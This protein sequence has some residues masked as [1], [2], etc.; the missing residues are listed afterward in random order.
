MATLQVL[1][2]R[3]DSIQK[4]AAIT[5]AMYQIS[6]SKL[7][8][9]QNAYQQYYKFKDAFD[10]VLNDV[11]NVEE[12]S[13]F[14]DKKQKSEKKLFILISGD[15]GLVGGYHVQ[16]FKHFLE[17]IK[18][19]DR[20]N[21]FLITIGRRA[22]GFA[23]KQNLQT[24]NEKIILNHDAIDEAILVDYLEDLVSLYMADH[25]GEI[26]V[27]S[28][29][30]INSMSQVPENEVL[31]PIKVKSIKKKKAHDPYFYEG[32]K[33]DTISDLMMIYMQ[34]RI[35]GL[36]VDAKLSEYASRIMAMKNATDNATEALEKLSLKYHQARQHKITNELLDI[37]NSKL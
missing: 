23:G 34:S 22:H 12:H 10:E 8:S 29:K 14:L 26:S 19:M 18:D 27:F 36:I 15:R 21:I 11:L 30:F 28:N 5:K 31:L 9:A 24:I 32:S 3:I 33:V 37:S 6:S 16:L 7:V 2:S 1:K 20:S 25:Y 4:T 13:D 35:Y 17:H